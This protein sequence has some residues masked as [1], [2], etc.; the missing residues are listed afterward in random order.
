MTTCPSVDTNCTVHRDILA[1]LRLPNGAVFEVQ[2]GLQALYD[3]KE[4]LHQAYETLREAGVRPTH[5]GAAT[6][7]ALR[8]AKS[9][10]LQKFVASGTAIAPERRC[11]W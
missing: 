2:L 9:G 1:S 5:I 3:L 4:G 11:N 10:C 8:L 6:V 7:A